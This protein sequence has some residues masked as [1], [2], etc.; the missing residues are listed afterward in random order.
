[1]GDDG[2]N[3]N[4]RQETIRGIWFPNDKERLEMNDLFTNILDVLRSTT[5]NSQSSI[6]TLRSVASVEEAHAEGVA[7]SSFKATATTTTATTVA[8][9]GR[10]AATA[11]LF[12]SLNIGGVSNGG[13]AAAATTPTQTTTTSRSASALVS[14]T[15][16]QQR[17]GRIQNTNT[18]ATDETHQQPTLDKKSLQLALLSLIQDERFLDLL[19]A[20]YLKVHHA[21]T[22]K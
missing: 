9:N 13:D 21:R 4:T 11:A 1:M 12:A 10:N 15:T 17:S 5:T 14:S 19:H 6:P 16:Q 7:S 22:K 8:P 18:N 2:D 3:G 20:Q